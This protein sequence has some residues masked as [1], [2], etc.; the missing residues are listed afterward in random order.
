MLATWSRWGEVLGRKRRGQLLQPRP[1]LVIERNLGTQISSFFEAPRPADA[2]LP[3][4]EQLLEQDVESERT[5]LP[6]DMTEHGLAAKNLGDKLGVES[7]VWIRLMV[8]SD[9]TA[10]PNLTVV[11]PPDVASLADRGRPVATQTLLRCPPQAQ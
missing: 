10:S 11:L 5:R 9:S 4:A 8:G 2:W 7:P 3:A 1:V 6:F